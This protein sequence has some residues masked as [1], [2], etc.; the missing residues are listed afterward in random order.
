MLETYWFEGKQYTFGDC[1]S[2]NLCLV[3]IDDEIKIHYVSPGYMLRFHPYEMPGLNRKAYIETGDIRLLFKAPF[4]KAY[5][6]CR[7]TRSCWQVY[8][9]MTENCT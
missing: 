2:T 3:P 1:T 4:N 5:H 7:P 6:V 8:I 9:A